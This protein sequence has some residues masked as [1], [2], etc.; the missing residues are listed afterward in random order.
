M[1]TSIPPMISDM[2]LLKY[3]GVEFAMKFAG[4]DL[5]EKSLL[6][7]V[8]DGKK[9]V[10]VTKRLL[11]SDV[12]AVLAFFQEPGF[13]EP[14]EFQAV[15]EAPHSSAGFSSGAS[16]DSPTFH[17][18]FSTRN[19]PTCSARIQSSCPFSRSASGKW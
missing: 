16:H 15:V 9:D 19:P 6:V 14:G 7:C 17:L 1:A 11:C 18:E 5:H 3:K 8:V 4:V 13:Q 10:L 12:G 2:V